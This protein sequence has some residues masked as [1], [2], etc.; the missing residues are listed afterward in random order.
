MDLSFGLKSSVALN[1][2]PTIATMGLFTGLLPIQKKGKGEQKK[3][4]KTKRNKIEEEKLGKLA[5]QLLS[6]LFRINNIKTNSPTNLLGPALFVF[7]AKFHPLEKG[8][9]VPPTSLCKR[10]WQ[11]GLHLS[12]H[13]SCIV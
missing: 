9:L 1:T 12:S 2:K 8:E 7:H 6:Q 10:A 5:T 11:T 4:N 3:K 13:V